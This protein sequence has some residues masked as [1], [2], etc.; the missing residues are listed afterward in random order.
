MTA[1]RVIWGVA[2]WIV[3]GIKGTGFTLKMFLTGAFINAVPGIVLQ[4]ILIPAIMLLLNQ[5]GLVPF[6]ERK[7]DK[8]ADV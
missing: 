3:L 8:S 7:T 4:L 5:T 2:Q 6:A 1:G